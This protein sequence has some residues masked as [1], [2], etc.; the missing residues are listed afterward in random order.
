MTKSAANAWLFDEAA[1]MR[2]VVEAALHDLQEPL[3]TVHGYCELLQ[4]RC[5]A[6]LDDEARQFIGFAIGGTERLQRLMGDL[7][8]LS[9]LITRPLEARPVDLHQLVDDVIEQEKRQCEVLIVRSDINIRRRPVIDR[10][11]IGRALLELIDNAAKFRGDDAPEITLAVEDHGDSI[12]IDISDNGIGVAPVH[13][14]YI[15]Q[16]CR[17]LHGRDRYPGSGLGLTMVGVIAARH[18]GRTRA[19]VNDRGGLGVSVDLAD[20]PS[21]PPWR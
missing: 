17:R 18:G 10:E 12:E 1:T 5:A 8:R 4:R 19:R 15:F 2:R 9:Q 11:M 3:R 20:L 6:D 14:D 7:S 21:D 13:L 16:P